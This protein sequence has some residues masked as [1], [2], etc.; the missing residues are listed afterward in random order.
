MANV[1]DLTR[2][3]GSGC[4]EQPGLTTV[5][6]QREISWY[7]ASYAENCV[8]V[9]RPP[10]MTWKYFVGFE[11]GSLLACI[12]A[13]FEQSLPPLIPIQ[14]ERN[15]ECNSW[16]SEFP[17]FLLDLSWNWEPEAPDEVNKAIRGSP[18]RQDLS[19]LFSSR[20]AP[21]QLHHLNIRF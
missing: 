8:Q 6:T 9:P 2:Y 16:R 7:S 14:L 3:F 1:L 13:I 17:K 5:C 19:P 10:L 20:H 21:F 4:W 18:N 11:R 15:W 12:R